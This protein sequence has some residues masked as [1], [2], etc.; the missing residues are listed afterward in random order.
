LKHSPDHDLQCEER[1]TY[2][3]WLQ[4]VFLPVFADQLTS[5]HLD[6]NENWGVAPGY[7]DGEDL[8][9]SHLKTLTLGELIIGHHD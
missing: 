5:L 6:F 8:L 2:E 1:R 7:F 3:P 9:F 4:T